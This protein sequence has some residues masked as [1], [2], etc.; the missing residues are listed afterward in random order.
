MGARSN[1]Q[2]RM[3]TPPEIPSL[4]AILIKVYLKICFYFV[5]FVLL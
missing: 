2:E 3:F 1:E 4:G 5:F